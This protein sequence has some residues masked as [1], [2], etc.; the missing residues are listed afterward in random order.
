[1][2]PMRPALIM[3]EWLTRARR[4]VVPGT[5]RSGG[6]VRSVCQLNVYVLRDYGWLR[7]R[8]ERRCVDAAGSDIPWLTYP[9]IDFLAQ[10]D[11]SDKRVLEYGSGASTLFWARRAAEVV[12]IETDADWFETVRARASSN[13]DLI[14]CMPAA[15]EYAAQIDA[16]GKFDVVVVDGPGEPRPAC[17]RHALGALA[18]T[19]MIVLDDSDLWPESAAILRNAGLIQVDFTGFAPLLPHAHTTSVFLQRGYGFKPRNGRQPEKSVAQ[20]AEPWPGF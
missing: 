9:A 15:N 2:P 18:D 6:L 16:R 20:P 12:S 5:L 8:R 1:M 13:C 10:L 17:C 7:S 19:W 11:Y 14:F 4:V 3:R